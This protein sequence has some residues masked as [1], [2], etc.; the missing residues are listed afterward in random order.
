MLGYIFSDRV[1][2]LAE[3]LGN[4]TW[5]IVGLIAAAI[6]GWKLFRYFRDSGETPAKPADIA[7]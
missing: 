4:V 7:A 1:Q 5:V 6:L 3:L 2:E